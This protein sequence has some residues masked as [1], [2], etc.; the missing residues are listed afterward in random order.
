MM[1][2]EVYRAMCALMA[3]MKELSLPTDSRLLSPSPALY[4][5]LAPREPAFLLGKGLKRTIDHRRRV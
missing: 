3:S 1:K 4:E 2:E 5:R